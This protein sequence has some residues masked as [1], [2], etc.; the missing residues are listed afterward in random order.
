MKQIYRCFI[1]TLSPIH[2][3]CDEVYEPMGFVVDENKNEL[4]AFDPITFISQMSESDKKSFSGICSTGTIESILEIYKFL[5]R[6]N[7]SGKKV[8][9]CPGFVVHYSKTLAMSVKDKKSVQQE[10]NRF[11]ISRTSFLLSDDRPY[12]PGSSIKGSLRT[13]YLNRLA[14]AKRVPS[15]GGK[16]AASDLE[17]ELLAYKDIS[18]DP[19]RMVKISD[20]MPVGNAQTKI[21]YGVNIK[22]ASGLAAKGPY[23]IIEVIEPGNMFSGTIEVEAPLSKGVINNPVKLEDLLEGSRVF[24]FGEYKREYGELKN[25]SVSAPDTQF[26]KGTVP[27]RLG[28]HSGAESI[29]I[30]GHR[31]IKIMTGQGNP[32]AYKDRATTLW[33][34]ADES[35][36]QNNKT[37]KPFGWAELC[38]IDVS[39]EDGFKKA[40]AEW[41]AH[42][43]LSFDAQKNISI[44]AVLPI[45]VETVPVTIEAPPKAP[46]YIIWEKAFVAYAKNNGEITASFENKKAFSNDK[47]IIPEAMFERLK[48]KSIKTTVEVE[49]YGRIFRLLK[50]FD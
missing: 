41:L 24:Y 27:I 5:R 2:I 12:I 50:I 35:R 17:K 43:R 10:L 37:L 29:T 46:E 9:L 15:S 7:T 4:T 39:N 21:T 1:K 22:K 47:S 23:Q 19:F 13:A 8:Q 38:E 14:K 40:E 48:K 3:G 18:T 20:F 26:S 16:H 45:N 42:R 49:P 6:R 28:R 33:L 44:P 11:T 31:S 32:P 30:E 36:P 25:D 34:A